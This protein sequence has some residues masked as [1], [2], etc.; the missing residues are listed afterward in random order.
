MSYLLLLYGY[1][2]HLELHSK[3]GIL[4]MLGI[5]WKV[6]QFDILI[7]RESSQSSKNCP[8]PWCCPFSSSF[9]T[10]LCSATL[11]PAKIWCPSR[12][13]Y[14]NYQRSVM[15]YPETV[16]I[17]PRSV[18]LNDF[19]LTQ[20]FILLLIYIMLYISNA[21]LYFTISEYFFWKYTRINNLLVCFCG[22]DNLWLSLVSTVHL[23]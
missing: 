10:V 14:W 11:F 7:K 3:N 2:K 4:G 6:G 20:A 5:N 18:F 16:L 22:E 19:I 21:F 23:M 15:R 1:C 8:A 12:D 9:K 17:H 13:L